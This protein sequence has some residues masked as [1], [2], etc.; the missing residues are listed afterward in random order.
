MSPAPPPPTRL[1]TAPTFIKAFIHVHTT[2]LTFVQGTA[3]GSEVRIKQ[4]LVLAPRNASPV[5]LTERISVL[6]LQSRFNPNICRPGHRMQ[7]ETLISY[8]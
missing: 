3:Q 5:A 2:G 8:V 6:T 1:S 4:A 7:I